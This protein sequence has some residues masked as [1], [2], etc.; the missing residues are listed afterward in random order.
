[1]LVNRTLEKNA[2]G[3]LKEHIVLVFYWVKAREYGNF[4]G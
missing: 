1:V 3:V 2:A 4:V